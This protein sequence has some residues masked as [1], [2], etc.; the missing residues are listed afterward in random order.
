MG[1]AERYDEHAEECLGLSKSVA[2]PTWRAQLVAMSAQWRKLAELESVRKAQEGDTSH[3]ARCAQEIASYNSRL[4]RP[5]RRDPR[6][7]S[8]QME[9]WEA[10]LLHLGC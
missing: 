7:D 5:D 3:R 2:D 1:A 8:G 10:A 6:E 9:G 4:V